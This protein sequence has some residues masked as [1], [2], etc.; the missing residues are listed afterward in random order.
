MKDRQDVPARV[1]ETAA[2]ALGLVERDD[3]E[4]PVPRRIEEA[5]MRAWDARHDASARPRYRVHPVWG[6]LAAAACAVLIATLWLSDAGNTG[7]M[8][9]P[10][11]ASAAAPSP[12]VVVS[13]L[14]SFAPIDALLQE[15][16][17]SLQLVRL[18]VQPSVLAALGYPLADPSDTQPL[19]VEV[20]V[21]LDGVPRAVR[22]VDA[23]V[24]SE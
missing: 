9:E 14:E 13:Q 17:A 5:V 18:S 4:T 6:A 22:R 8:V 23:I 20:L 7:S 10:S 3:A 12:A 1:D 16:P 15:E 24:K 21:G 11:G 2:Q 19:D